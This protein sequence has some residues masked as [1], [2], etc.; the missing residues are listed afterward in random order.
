MQAE[1]QALLKNQT[2]SLVTLPPHR[3]AI[4]YK[5]VFR[6]KENVN[7][8]TNKHK[9]RLVV[10]CFHQVHGFEFHE[11]FSPVI[12]LMIICLI[13]TLAITNKWK[14]KQ[15]N[16]NNAFLNDTLDDEVYI[17]QPTDFTSNGP[18]LVCRLHKALYNPKQTST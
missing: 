4:G 18:S 17:E 16:I 15:L 8:F 5:C 7:G 2:S 11:T 12:K 13:L 1:Y 14:I 3:K 10:K 6:I 9:V